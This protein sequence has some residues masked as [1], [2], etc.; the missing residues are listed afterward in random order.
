MSDNGIGFD[1]K[2]IKGKCLK[3]LAFN[4]INTKQ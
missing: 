2:L 3:L 4:L 1:Y